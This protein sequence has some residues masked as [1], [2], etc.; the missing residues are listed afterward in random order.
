MIFRGLFAA[1]ILTPWFEAARR[2]VS[3]DLPGAADICVAIGTRPDEAYA[4]LRCA[5]LF[6]HAGRRPAAEAQLDRALAF[7]R[8]VGATTYMGQAETL[9][10]ASA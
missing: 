10:S 4:R 9:L 3:G 2:V 1:N 8:S 7:Y 5:E 6:V